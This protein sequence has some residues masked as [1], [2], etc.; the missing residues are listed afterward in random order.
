[1]TEKGR[2]IQTPS[3]TVFYWYLSATGS[4]WLRINYN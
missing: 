1:M 4:N 2:S 3:L